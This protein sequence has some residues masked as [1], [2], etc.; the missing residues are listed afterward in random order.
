MRAILLTI[1]IF[2][3][4]SASQSE[5]AFE[6]NHS[7]VL[8]ISSEKEE[9][10]NSISSKPID[11]NND[12]CYRALSECVT[13]YPCKENYIKLE[14]Y[15]FYNN[16]LLNPEAKNQWEVTY[17]IDVVNN[18]DIKI[19]DVLLNATLP[20]NLS[21]VS[22]YYKY[23]DQGNLPYPTRIQN[24]NKTTKFLS[25]FLGDIGPDS[26]IIIVLIANYQ[27]HENVDLE[28]NRVSAVG[29][30]LCTKY[31]TN[32]INATGPRGSIIVNQSISDVSTTNNNSTI[33]YLIWITNSGQCS[34]KDVKLMDTLPRNMT[35]LNSTP[36]A[37]DLGKNG[38]VFNLGNLDRGAVR[39]IELNATYNSK[40]LSIQMKNNS[41]QV[42][43]YGFGT[44]VSST[45]NEAHIP[46]T[47][48]VFITQFINKIEEKD[49]RTLVTYDVGI[50]NQDYVRLTN[51]KLTNILPKNMTYINAVYLD[52]KKLK[53]I[54]RKTDKETKR[55]IVKWAL[56]ELDT[57]KAAKHVFI[58][59]TY[60][61]DDIN[62]MI[63]DS[64][65]VL[66]A[67]IFGKLVDSANSKALPPAN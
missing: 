25:W 8:N 26:H 4:T 54:S 45:N 49:N 9:V 59:A 27:D 63:N 18:G 61:S 43:G 67:E 22:S 48:R 37:I 53:E 41:I 60:D 1:L 14:L 51:V 58:K 35:Y 21:Y 2:A 13:Q 7:D 64:Q 38:A 34:L 12:G 57:R 42:I 11:S 46:T 52:G 31:Q 44:P 19:R 24:P 56:G 15:Q 16:P 6:Y 39:K 23:A 65:I 5:I 17:E 10:L 28:L 20:K 30:A 3:L 33:T 36:S 47:S 29:K 55:T 50:S 62:V 66:T 32:E 40:D